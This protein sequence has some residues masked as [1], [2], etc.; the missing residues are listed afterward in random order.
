[1]AA[2][3]SVPVDESSLSEEDVN[4][5]T[6]ERIMRWVIIFLSVLVLLLTVI[7]VILVAQQ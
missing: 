3:C 1:M 6:S 2:Y 5:W 4:N 7:T